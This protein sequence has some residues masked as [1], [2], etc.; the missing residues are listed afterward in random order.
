[1][2]RFVMTLQRS[3]TG[4]R[5]RFSFI[6]ACL[7]VGLTATV[8]IGC[9]EE[10]VSGIDETAEDEESETDEGD[11]EENSSNDHRDEEGHGVD[12]DQGEDEVVE[13]GFMNGSWRAGTEEQDRP[14]VYFDT[15]HDEGDTEVTGTYLMGNGLVEQFDGESGE[16][17]S[18]QFDGERF[19]VE[20]NPSADSREMYTLEAE[21]VDEDTL[22]GRVTAEQNPEID[23]SLVL[24]RRADE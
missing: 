23:H 1:M 11:E 2:Q 9:D 16:L 24:T 12:P 22:E 3:F 5:L 15:F 21:R 13:A 4:H 18:A 7:A 17:E 8:L 14:A 6:A 10:R 19:V 20:W